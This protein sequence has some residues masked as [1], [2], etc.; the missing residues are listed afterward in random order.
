MID[1]TYF[2]HMSK[3]FVKFRRWCMCMMGTNAR[4]VDTPIIDVSVIIVIARNVP[5]LRIV[6]VLMYTSHKLVTLLRVRAK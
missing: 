3:W 6:P 2:I 4:S 1:I 5:I